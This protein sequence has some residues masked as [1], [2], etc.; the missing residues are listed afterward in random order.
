VKRKGEWVEGK[1][2]C[3]LGNDSDKKNGGKEERKMYVP[4]KDYK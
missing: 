2:N 3:W 4:Q 1:R